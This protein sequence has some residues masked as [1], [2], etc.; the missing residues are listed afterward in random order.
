MRYTDQTSMSVWKLCYFLGNGYQRQSTEWWCMQLSHLQAKLI[1]LHS[2][3]KF[4]GCNFLNGKMGPFFVILQSKVIT[5]RNPNEE[6]IVFFHHLLDLEVDA[7]LLSFKS[8]QLATK[9]HAATSSLLPPSGGMERRKD[10]KS[11]KDQDKDWGGSL[12]SCG[13]NSDVTSGSKIS[14]I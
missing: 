5:P 11:L 9:N 2:S 1:F 4:M 10:D 13:Q 3:W 6:E 8:P 12:T 14:L 7:F